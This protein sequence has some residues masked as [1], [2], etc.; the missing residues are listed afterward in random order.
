MNALRLRSLLLVT[1]VTVAACGDNEVTPPDAAGPDAAVPGPDA[2][3]PAADAGATDATVC[4]PPPAYVED[5]SACAPLATDY[6]PRV[7]MLAA[8][9]WPVCISD[10]GVYHRIMESIATIGRVEAYEQIAALLWDGGRVPTADDFISARVI[11]AVDQG[12]DSRV[13]RRHDIHYPAPSDGTTCADPGVPELHPDRCVGP[14]KLLPI[15]NDAFVRGA[16]G[17]A[18]RVHAA[19]IE[20]ALLWFL[21]V[22]TLSEALSCTTRP[23]DCD[24]AWAYYTGGTPIDAPIGLAR[25]IVAI[26]SG[27]H[28]RAHDGVLAVRCWRNLDNETGVAVDLA[29]RDLAREQ[30][31]HALVRGLALLVRDRFDGLACDAEP[32]AADARYAALEVLLPLLDRAARERDPAAADRLLGQ[33]GPGGVAAVEVN[34]ALATLDGLFGCP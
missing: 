24:S 27:T 8:D 16:M 12:L 9:R 14:A 26:G 10:D 20:A 2:T 21:Y 23:Q 28:D 4:F 34:A 15:L 22:S 17:E 6:Q 29:Q 3:V 33:L 7:D 30:L 31:D 13:Q 5:L 1:V 19:R 32:L 11:Y 25:A 18:P